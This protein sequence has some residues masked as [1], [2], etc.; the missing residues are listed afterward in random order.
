MKLRYFTLLMAVVFCFGCLGA[1]ATPSLIVYSYNSTW[2]TSSSYGGSDPIF[3]LP[4]STSCGS[5][6]EPVCEATG[7]WYF[8]QTWAGAPSYISFSGPGEQ[9][10]DI[11]M[12]DSLGPGGAF[13]I[14]FFSDPSLPDPSLYA[15]YI[16][17]TD[18]FE[19][20]VSGGVSGPIPV[21]CILNGNFLN[22]VLASD[23]EAG[24]DPFGVGFDTSDG[25]QFQGAAYGPEPS[26]LLLL[27]SGVLGA[28]GVVRRRFRS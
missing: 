4:A 18:I 3:V 12:F 16:H 28:L 1:S 7:S 27:G 15:G 13:R 6:N 9:V 14:L 11:I 19:D 5:E 2:V 17:Y 22:V 25:I 10:S 20:P 23:G 26:S 24:F 8:N 21:C